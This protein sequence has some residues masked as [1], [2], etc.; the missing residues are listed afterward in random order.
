MSQATGSLL[1]EADSAAQ[2][3][4][5]LKSSPPLSELETSGLSEC[6][7]SPNGLIIMFQA[8]KTMFLT[9]GSF[10]METLKLGGRKLL[11]DSQGSGL[12]SVIVLRLK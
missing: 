7:V 9:V 12:P 6:L 1:P 4:G 8:F 3:R 10:Q 2:V 11:A 5:P